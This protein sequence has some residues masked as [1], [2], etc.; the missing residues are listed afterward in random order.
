M[1]NQW[2]EAD[3]GDGKGLQVVGK[4][5]KVLQKELREKMRRCSEDLIFFKSNGN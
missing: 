3:K 1:T 4:G 5:C 2:I